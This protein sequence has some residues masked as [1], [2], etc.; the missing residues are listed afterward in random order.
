VTTLILQSFPIFR[1][2]NLSIVTA[3][4]LSSA[5]GGTLVID[6]T[7]KSPPRNLRNRGTPPVKA[8]LTFFVSTSTRHP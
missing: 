3:H 5:E 2:A 1:V 4:K 7:S 6:E 8:S